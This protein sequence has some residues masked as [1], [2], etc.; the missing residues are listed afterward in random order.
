MLDPEQ[1]L[2]DQAPFD[3]I[4]RFQQSKVGEGDKPIISLEQFRG[5][6]TK[7]ATRKDN[8][9]RNP[10]EIYRANVS[11]FRVNP[12]ELF[13]YYNYAPVGKHPVNKGDAK[14]VGPALISCIDALENIPYW[15]EYIAK[16]LSNRSYL[17]D[18]SVLKRTGY[19]ETAKG[20]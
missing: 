3:V 4:T 19:R 8:T 6:I 20:F 12:E 11:R 2:Y 7:I 18:G 5:I 1:N 16:A 14:I 15:D 9:D 10:L 13:K 17:P